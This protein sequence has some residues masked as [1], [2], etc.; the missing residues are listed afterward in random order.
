MPKK[1][2]EVDSQSI[3]EDFIGSLM[4][5]HSDNMELRL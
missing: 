2:M 4:C 5:S 3:L 1:V